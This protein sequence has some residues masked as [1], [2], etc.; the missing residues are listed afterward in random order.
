TWGSDHFPIFLDTSTAPTPGSRICFTVNWDIFR[1]LSATPADGDFLQHVVDSAKAA[2]V[3]SRTKHG[4]PVP[5]LKQLQ[6]WATREKGRAPCH[7]E[8]RG[9]GLDSFQVA[10]RCLQTPRKTDDGSRA[11]K[12]SAVPSPAL[13]A[14]QLRGGFCGRYSMGQ[15]S[16]SLSLRWP[17]P[18]ASRSWL[19]RT[20]HGESV[21]R[22]ATREYLQRPGSPTD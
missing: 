21:H 11:G 14:V 1:R 6:L 17:S 5:G 12:A 10:G 22:E 3:V 9:G 13:G 8:L 15:P 2:T 4:R 20:P 18:R 19:W 16:V 7:P